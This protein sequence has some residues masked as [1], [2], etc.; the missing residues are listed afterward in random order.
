MSSSGRVD[1]SSPSF[2]GEKPIER[3]CTSLM[4]YWLSSSIVFLGLGMGSALI[5]P[6]PVRGHTFQHTDAPYANWDGQWYAEIVARGYVL[7]CNAH[8]SVAFFPGYPV[9]ARCVARLTGLRN[10]ESL[11]VT[12]NALLAATFVLLAE[13]LRV[14][15]AAGSPHSTR[16][17]SLLAFGLVPTTFFF[18]VAYSES[19]FLFLTTLALFGMRR[20][21]PLLVLAAV[22]GLATATRAVG[23]ALSVALLWH[24]WRR[25]LGW[26]S[27]AARAIVLVPVSCWGLVA[28]MAYQAAEFGDP[29]AFAKA[30]T[31][32]RHRPPAVGGARLLALATLE[33]VRALFDP[34]GPAY[35]AVLGRTGNPL[36]SLRA[37]D[38][39]YFLATSLLVILGS[40]RRWL[41]GEEI[42]VAAGMLLVPYISTAY[43]QH[44]QSAGR[45]AAVVLPAYFVLGRLLVKLPAPILAVLAALCGFFLGNARF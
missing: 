20:R 35:T 44:M 12:S 45:Y 16:E 15:D 39:F 4:V 1:Q 22:I 6:S 19:L 26:P 8:S 2:S 36:L 14:R 9:L 18:R 25:S 7:D 13:Y 29:L 41:T 10:E 3:W 28:Y 23:I 38:P 32:W 27:F 37:A 33:P 31:S 21:W 43:E 11:L 30:Q 42:V 5:R 17:A 34:A 40:A 24:T